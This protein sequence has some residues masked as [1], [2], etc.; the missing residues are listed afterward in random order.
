MDSQRLILFFVFSLS[1]FF[2]Y[3]SWHRDQTKAAEAVTA[4]A[5]SAIPGA[6]AQKA[7]S[8]TPAPSAGLS[9]PGAAPLAV[10]AVDGGKLISVETDIYKAQVSTVGGDLVRLEL[11]RHGGTLDPKKP[12]VLFERSAT[13]TY[14]AQSGLGP[15]EKGLPNH[16][17]SYVAA[18]DSYRLADGSNELEVRLESS[19][20]D[21]KTVKVLRFTRG[22][23]LIQQRYEVTNGS[24]SALEVYG[25]FQLVRDAKPPEGDS[26]M[27]PTFT[28]AAVY[29]EQEKF[30][31]VA[32]SDFEKGKFSYP[33]KQQRWLGRHTAALFSGGLV[34]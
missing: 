28:G 34:A 7:Q 25:Y 20:G 31:K 33:K 3:E 11:R 5:P 12:F 29:T 15:A 32:F 4:A 9:L 18:A 17:T 13:H 14:V 30:Q 21:V 16:L 24:Q 22:S 6:P 23:Y 26:S 1:V 27:V 8:L 19:S 10:N 2:L